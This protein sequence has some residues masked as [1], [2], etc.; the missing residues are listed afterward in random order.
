MSLNQKEN[1]SKKRRHRFGA[2]KGALSR[3]GPGSE[4]G[5]FMVGMENSTPSRTP[6]DGQR[7]VMALRRV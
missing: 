1:I 2:A 3:S 4:C 5:Y 7:W 6:A